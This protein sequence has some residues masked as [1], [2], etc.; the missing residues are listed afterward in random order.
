VAAHRRTKETAIR[1]V[2]MIGRIVPQDRATSTTSG[3]TF[4]SELRRA[5]S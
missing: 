1:I 3:D 2:Y 5:A 4:A